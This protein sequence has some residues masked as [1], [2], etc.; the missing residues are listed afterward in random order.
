MH[1]SEPLTCSERKT[2]LAIARASLESHVKNGARPDTGHLDL[3]AALQEARGAFVTLTI[4]GRLRGCIGYVEPIKPLWEAVV[5]NAANA[6]LRD[7][8]F[9]SVTPGELSSIQ[10]EISAMSPL[11]PV[12]DHSH[13]E[14]GRH[15]IMLTCG[16]SHGLLLPQVAVEYDWDSAEFLAHTCRKAG[17]PDDAWKDSGAII[18]VFSA[19]VFAGSYAP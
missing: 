3:T 2:L 13:I 15:G 4:R 11:R 6:A 7:P 14:V 5:E 19:E 12:T 16:I 9:G 17:L 8:R 10:I 1:E 18:E